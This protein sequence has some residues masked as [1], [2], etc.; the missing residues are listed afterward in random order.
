MDTQPA[1]L[2]DR[3]AGCGRASLRRR[4]LPDM[5]AGKGEDWGARLQRLRLL[6]QERQGCPAGVEQPPLPGVEQEPGLLRIEQRVSALRAQL[7]GL[8]LAESGAPPDWDPGQE[9]LRRR[10]L[11]FDTETT[12]LSGG[13][14]LVVFLLGVLR[15]EDAPTPGWCLRQ[16]LCVSPAAAGALARAWLDE[17][18]QGTILVSYNGKRFDV[19]VLRNQG[20]LHGCADPSAGQAHWDLLYPVRRRFRTQWPNCR[21]ATVEQRLFGFQRKHD[22]PGSEAPRAWRSWLREGRSADLLRVLSHNR[23]DLETLLRLLR[24]LVQ[25]PPVAEH[26]RP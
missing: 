1:S 19:P 4:S 14:G 7:H 10:L 9:M 17:C 8:D 23:R 3:L 16:Y 26:P 20:V 13:V 15:W 22:L 24:T 6:A 18:R 21:L 12:G 11:F 25:S 5:P 2:R